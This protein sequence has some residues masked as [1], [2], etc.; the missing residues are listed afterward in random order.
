MKGNGK[1]CMAQLSRQAR[2]NNRYLNKLVHKLRLIE[3]IMRDTELAAIDTEVL[4]ETNASLEEIQRTSES[5]RKS[6]QTELASRHK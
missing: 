3:V 4:Q 6:I 5:L 1:R 2:I